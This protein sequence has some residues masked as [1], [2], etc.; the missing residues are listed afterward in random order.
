M[1]GLQLTDYI[2]LPST[3][4]KWLGAARQPSLLG[5]VIQQTPGRCCSSAAMPPLTI[6][7]S[8]RVTPD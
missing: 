5:L 2:S 1:D 6:F 7:S 3:G 8:V 4:L